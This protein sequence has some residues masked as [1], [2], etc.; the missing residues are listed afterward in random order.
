MWCNVGQKPI[1][2]AGSR[3]DALY[4]PKGK[5]MTANRPTLDD[6]L[7]VQRRF[8]GPPAP[9]QIPKLT[10]VARRED[11]QEMLLDDLAKRIATEVSSYKQSS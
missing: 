8:I 6:L 4:R 5:K 11:V 3:P 7:D 1:V 2:T 9:P 10:P